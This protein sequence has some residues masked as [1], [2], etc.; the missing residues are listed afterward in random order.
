MKRTTVIG[1]AKA[2][3]VS[4][5]VGYPLRFQLTVGWSAQSRVSLPRPG[6]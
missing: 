5:C 6:T 4:L 2:G 3:G 1:T